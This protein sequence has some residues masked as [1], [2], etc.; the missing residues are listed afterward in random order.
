M[1][2]E[3]T[4]RP[5]VRRE[6]LLVGILPGRIGIVAT[7][8]SRGVPHDALESRSSG[9]GLSPE[10]PAQRM[11]RAYRGT[12]AYEVTRAERSSGGGNS[13]IQSWTPGDPLG[14]AKAQGRASTTSV[15]S[16]KE[17]K[18]MTEPSREQNAARL[19]I[20]ENGIPRDEAR[21]AGYCA[22][23]GV[24]AASDGAAPE[25]FGEVFC[26]EGHAEEFVKGVRAA[27]GQA[28]AAVE[29][30]RAQPRQDPDSVAASPAQPNWK[31]LLKMAAC[32][33]A[34]LLALVVLA[35]GGGALLGAAG[36]LLPVLA[37]LACPV[38]MYF[39]MR[40]MSKGHQQQ[41]K[42]KDQDK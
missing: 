26:S 33:G 36:A 1:S 17:G 10:L 31:R 32:C 16:L 3:A 15:V 23:C 38:G 20:S 14:L 18:D 40:G 27:R 28:A 8:T 29:A 9:R 35:G 24:E 41:P 11:T 34:P 5:G 39:M 13:V 22:F 25:R 7:V 6:D 30:G 37:L 42:D 12:R 19:T 4:G 21:G 2:G